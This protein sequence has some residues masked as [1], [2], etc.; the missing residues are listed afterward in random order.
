MIYLKSQQEIEIMAGGGRILAEIIK[1]LSDAVKPGITTK[2][3]DKL[4]GELILFYAK[5][6]SGTVEPAFLGYGGYPANICTSV[7]DEVVHCVPSGLELKEGKIISLDVGIKYNGF[8]LDSAATLPVLGRM[9]YEAWSKRNPELHKLLE[10]TKEALNA[11]I[12]Q[13]KIG[14]HIGDISQAVQSVVERNRFSVIRELVG[15]GIGRNLHEE[16]QVPNFGSAGEGVKLQE[17]MVI[18]IEP[19]VSI[20]DWRLVKGADGFTYKTKDGSYAAHF[21]HTIAIT[22]EGPLILTV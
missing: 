13:A 9:D 20:G 21:E 12:K 11:G 4:A 15:H 19:M 3:I 8:Y 5:Q 18:A 7:N 17:G 10:V 22:A 1:K 14:N 16:P 6:E 2:D